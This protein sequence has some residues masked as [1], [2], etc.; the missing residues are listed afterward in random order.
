MKEK[1][2]TL[3]KQ[4]CLVSIRRKKINNDRIQGF[5]LDFS[6]NL[7]LIQHVS[8]F[9]LDGLTILRVMDISNIESN[10]TDQVQ[11]EI[12]KANGVFAQVNFDR[13]YKLTNWRSVFS[14]LASE[15]PLITIEDE[16]DCPILMVGQ[17]KNIREKSVKIHEFTSSGRWLGDISEMNYKAIN[18]FRVGNHY[19]NMYQKYFESQGK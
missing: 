5:I 4:K 17:L 3:K 6:K 12:L 13:E 11:T 19:A 16:G 18:S 9:H 15:Y 14:T 10:K 2:S 1:I 8:N 7:I